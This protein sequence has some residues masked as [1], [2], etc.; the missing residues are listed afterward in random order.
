MA[1]GFQRK[2][3][4]KHLLKQTLGWKEVG[5]GIYGAK[6]IFGTCKG[7][8]KQNQKAQLSTYF[9]GVLSLVSF[10]A[11]CANLYLRTV[12]VKY[13]LVCFQQTANRL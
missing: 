10:L 12:L 13:L 5:W 11:P 3:T 4:E 2:S 9:S 7:E 1:L 6:C 8:I